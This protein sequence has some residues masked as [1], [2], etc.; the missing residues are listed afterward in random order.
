MQKVR[1]AAKRNTSS[2]SQKAKPFSWNY[3]ILPYIEQDNLHRFQSLVRKGDGGA[4]AM[5]L[6]SITDGTSNTM[7]I[8]ALTKET[9]TYDSVKI[10]S[11]AGDFTAH[12]EKAIVR[13]EDGGTGQPPLIL[14]GFMS[15]RLG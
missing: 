13:V 3:T 8:R 14:I 5:T 6:A 15:S 4:L 1:E 10:R 12:L 7:M 9:L 2:S 11:T